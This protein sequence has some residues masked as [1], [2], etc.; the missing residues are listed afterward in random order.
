M[1]KKWCK[2]MDFKDL[3]V[4]MVSQLQ[5]NKLEEVVIILKRIW[6]RRN[7]F[8]FVKHFI[9]PT[10]VYKATKQE[11]S[12]FQNAQQIHHLEIINEVLNRSLVK[13]EKPAS[14]HYKVN[15]DAS[16]DWKTNRMGGGV[17]V[18]DSQGNLIAAMC[19]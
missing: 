2:E 13:Q 16:F 17:M 7:H 3:W 6:F 15:W 19:F 1:Q 5:V 8:I 12:D 11:L 18:R 4:Q 10:T 14:N 9:H